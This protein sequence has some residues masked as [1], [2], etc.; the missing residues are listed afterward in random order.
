MRTMNKMPSVSK[1]FTF[2][3][4]PYG[5]LFK[6]KLLYKESLK[7]FSLK[8]IDFKQ[9]PSRELALQE[10]AANFDETLRRRANFAE[11]SLTK[12]HPSQRKAKISRALKNWIILSGV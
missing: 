11:Q 1:G 8:T 6:V 5:R 7:E 4:T 2:P 9:K 12:E 10:G 3:L